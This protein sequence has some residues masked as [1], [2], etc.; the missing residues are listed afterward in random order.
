MAPLSNDN[1]VQMERVTKLTDDQVAEIVQDMHY[2]I[3]NRVGRCLGDDPIVTL[4]QVA[5]I[6]GAL[7]PEHFRVIENMKGEYE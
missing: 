5:R 3:E 7:I 2:E 1:P 6:I 4:P